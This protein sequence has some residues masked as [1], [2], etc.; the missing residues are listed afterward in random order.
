[1]DLIENTEK[2]LE[3]NP[4]PAFLV[5]DGKVICANRAA[6]RHFVT[7][8]S[9]ISPMLLTGREEYASFTGDCLCLRLKIQECEYNASVQLYDQMHLFLL[10]SP[11][12]CP[13]LRAMALVAQELRLPLNGMIN[14]TDEL[15]PAVLQ[16]AP[17]SKQQLSQLNKNLHQLLRIVGNMSD[18]Y[19]YSIL[20]DPILETE[21]LTA[22]FREHFEK[23]SALL[24]ATNIRFRYDLP[25]KE[26]LAPINKE[27]LSKAVYNLVS[28]AVKFTPADGQIIATIR[29]DRKKLTF[30]LRNTGCV[31]AEMQR[32]P[33]HRFLRQPGIEDG[34]YGIGLGMELICAAANIH[35]GTVLMHP[36]S[37]NGVA[38]TMTISLREDAP[39]RV[40]SSVLKFDSL[41]GMDLG[42][43]Q[44]SDALP[45]NLYS[46]E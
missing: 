33:F 26:I 9:D 28:N 24:E 35:R 30:D 38:F 41:G 18:A 31:P 14:L 4:H 7:V 1:M 3:M 45:A 20:T 16:D 8:G 43:I 37:D 29:A 12:D 22:F 36:Y 27:I 25:Q 39:C 15:I 44:L 6:Q 17:D 21:N 46:P 5:K 23:I 40:R 10:E 19:N 42:L 34:R 2:L 13:E 11:K 32:N